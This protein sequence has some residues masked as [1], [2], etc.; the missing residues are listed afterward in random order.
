VLDEAVRQIEARR[1]REGR[2]VPESSPGR[3]SASR[4][5]ASVGRAILGSPGVLTPDQAACAEIAARA[6]LREM[7]LPGLAAAVAPLAL[8]LALRFARSE[9]NPVAVADSVAALVVAGTI[10]GV[11]GSLFLGNAGGAWDNAKKYIATGAHGGR[12]LVD[13]AGARADNPTYLAAANADSVGDPLKDLLGPALVVFVLM[14]S[15]VTLV[16]LP[17]FL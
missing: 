13:E 2:L 5:P 11:I 3:G 16:L 8:G 17:F 12:Y 4:P 9:D 7:V 14:L 6:A 1:L 15:V 10:A